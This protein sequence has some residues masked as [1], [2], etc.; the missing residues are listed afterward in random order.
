MTKSKKITL[1]IAAVVIIGLLV[2]AGLTAGE[3]IA[4]SFWSLFPPVV[5]IALAL[6]TKEVYSS[7]FI[8]VLTGALL[9]A[10]FS[11]TGTMDTLIGEGLIKAVED[12]AGIFI[13]PR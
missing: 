9:H 2:V 5:A 8:G 13:F 12:N 11:F 7:L 1:A 6:I 3:N 4:G 10:N